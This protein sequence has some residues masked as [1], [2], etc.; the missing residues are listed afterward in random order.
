M[1]L[2]LRPNLWLSLWSA[3]EVAQGNPLC[4]IVRWQMAY[5]NVSD[6]SGIGAP[7]KQC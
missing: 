5:Y 6:R 7:G 4:I 1:R 2:G 3:S